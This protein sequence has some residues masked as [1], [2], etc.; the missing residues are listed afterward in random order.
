LIIA[1]IHVVFIIV[2]VI[3]DIATDN[4]VNVNLAVIIV[5]EARRIYHFVDVV[6]VPA[7]VAGRSLVVF[8]C[9]AAASATA[10]PLRS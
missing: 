1:A 9:A 5:M 6:V 7:I 10:D 2:V 8:L 3:I 4:G